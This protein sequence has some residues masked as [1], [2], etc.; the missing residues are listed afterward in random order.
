MTGQKS[1]QFEVTPFEEGDQSKIRPILE[2][3]GWAEG[4]I[5]AFEKA[6]VSFGRGEDSAV[7]LAQKADCC[8]GFVFVE[9]HTWNNL[10]QLQ[11]LAVDPNAQRCG[12]ATSLVVQ[13][14]A[15]AYS[16][17]MRGIYVDTPVNNSGGRLFYE[18][19]G[20]QLGY[21]M[22][23]YYEDYLDGVT[24]QKFFS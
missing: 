17:E 5:T 2:R 9:C 14:E 3:I 21:L 10:A 1:I 6:A 24:Y 4:Y 16:H 13:A 12:V 7:Y 15:F 19:L 23:R 20:Y 22:P 11:G 8:V 18:A